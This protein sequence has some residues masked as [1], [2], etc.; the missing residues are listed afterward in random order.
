VTTAHHG[1]APVTANGLILAGC[2]CGKRAYE[3]RKV[4]KAAAKRANASSS[5][6]PRHGVGGTQLRFDAYACPEGPGWHV[7]HASARGRA[8]WREGKQK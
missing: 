6:K 4:A 7:G 3:S 5:A 8:S 1:R 2:S